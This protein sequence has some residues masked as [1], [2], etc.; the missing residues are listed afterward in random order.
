MK[1]KMLKACPF[2]QVYEDKGTN[3]WPANELAYIRADYDGYRWWNTIWPVNETLKTPR[4]AAELDAVYDAFRE[5]FPT[6]EDMKRY[7]QQELSPT[8]DPTE[9]NAFLSLEHGYYWLRMITR[10][11]DYNLYLHCYRKTI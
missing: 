6:L 9:F 8:Y 5:D 2:L 11:G 10:E 1:E 4:L 3:S 7:C